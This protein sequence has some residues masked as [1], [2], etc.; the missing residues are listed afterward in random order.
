MSRVHPR[1]AVAVTARQQQSHPM[2]PAS[3]HPAGEMTPGSVSLYLAR[4]P[5][6]DLAVRASQ[7]RPQA[8]QRLR[9]L[10]SSVPSPVRTVIS[11]ALIWA[12]SRIVMSPPVVA[13]TPRGT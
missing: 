8:A 7:A 2:L 9:A 4:Q 12:F 10:A 5:G 3:R 13:G 6:A 1:Y 11:A